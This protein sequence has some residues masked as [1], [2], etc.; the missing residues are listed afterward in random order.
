MS[1]PEVFSDRQARGS[2]RPAAEGARGALPARAGVACRRCRISRMRGGDPELE[3][4]SADELALEAERLEA[5]LK[6]ALV[7]RDP[8]DAKDVIV[9]I[10][11]GVGGDEAA[12]WA[13]RRPA[14][15][16]ALRRAPR[17]HDRGARLEPE[18]GGRL[19]GGDVR[20]QGRRRLLGLQVGGRHASGPARARDRV[21]GP[22]PHVDGDGR[23]DARG[24]GGRGGDR[25]GRPQDRRLPLD[26]PRRAERQHD[27][28][29]GPDHAP[30]DGPR[31]RDAGREVP[32][33]EQAE[34]AARP[35]RA[36]LRARAPATGGRSCRS[37]GGRRSASGERSEKIRTYNYP[38]NRVTDHRIKLTLHR[39]DAVLAGELDELTEGARRRG[40]A[41]RAR[42]TRR[43]RD[44]PRG[45]AGRRPASSRRPAADPA[46]RRG[47]AARR[48]RSVSR[49][50][51]STPLR[52]AS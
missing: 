6:L 23:G 22:H 36:A 7:E 30:A 8:N 13:A 29:G 34:G 26:R 42:G 32:A 27:R 43:S 52:T 20:R 31:R 50:P 25:P 24:R 16:D 17:L 19:Q 40:S 47:A 38:E 49:V 21:T 28:L 41:S 14:D 39:L 18:R 10:R 33:P 44:H 45:T 48:M 37:T 46:R 5:E 11:Q 1:D 9:E 15:A 2:A 51:S 4:T 3:L 35:A 12:L